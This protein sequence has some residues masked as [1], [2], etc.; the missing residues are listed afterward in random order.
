MFI[1]D[2][3]DA[4]TQMNNLGL[5]IFAGIVCPA[6]DAESVKKFMEEN[7]AEEYCMR[8]P[9]GT[10]GKFFFVTSVDEAMEKAKQYE[11]E[12]T[13]GVSARPYKEDIVLLGDIKVYKDENMVDLTARTDSEANH[14]N[15]Y[16]EPEYNMHISLDSD[17]LWNVPGFSKLMGY[18]STY[19]LYDIVVEFAVYSCK[20]GKYKDNVA[21]FE[22]RSE[23]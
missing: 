17:E 20:V 3:A 5:N 7:P 2:K 4:I 10:V 18:I 14:R 9:S 19:E 21:I 8:D 15:I 16:S 23:Y 1:R 22:L 13:L 6:D 12:F 11:E